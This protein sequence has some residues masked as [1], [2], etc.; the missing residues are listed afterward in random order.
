MDTIGH[1]A[2]E[3]LPTRSPAEGGR[4][5]L[6]AEEARLSD[7]GGGD[8]ERD[9]ASPSSPTSLLRMEAAHSARLEQKLQ[10]LEARI[11]RQE[12][13]RAQPAAAAALAERGEAEQRRWPLTQSAGGEGEPMVAASTTRHRTRGGSGAWL[14]QRASRLLGAC[15]VA[16]LCH[17]GAQR[18]AG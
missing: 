14:A 13:G 2:G 7:D 5:Q 3:L 15:G 11:A 9:L 17:T 6:R 10:E 12:T 1:L 4:T 8:E 18:R 16:L